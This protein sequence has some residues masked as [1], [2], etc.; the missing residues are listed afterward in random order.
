MEC[1]FVK[2]LTLLSS[3]NLVTMMNFHLH[4]DGEPL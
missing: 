4:N 1:E 2:K 3:G